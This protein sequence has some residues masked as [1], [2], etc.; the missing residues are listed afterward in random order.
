MK[1]DFRGCVKK[2]IDISGARR[3]NQDIA[4]ALRS[5]GFTPLWDNE[6]PEGIVFRGFLSFLRLTGPGLCRHLSA[7]QPLTNVI[8]N[9]IC[10]DSK[11]KLLRSHDASPPFA[12]G[13]EDGRTIIAYSFRFDKPRRR[14]GTEIDFHYI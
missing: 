3:Y 13:N 7:I 1:V 9:Y 14:G 10:H 5:H 12:P 8:R 6:P 4:K 11:N 2:E